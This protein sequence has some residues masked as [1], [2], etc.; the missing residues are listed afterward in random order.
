MIAGEEFNVAAAI[1]D[2]SE[3]KY[4]VIVG[5]DIL[6]RAGFLVDAARVT[7]KKGEGRLRVILSEVCPAGVEAGENSMFWSPSS[8]RCGTVAGARKT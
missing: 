5:R 2:R 3:M 7:A 1:A 6:G 8:R 4:H